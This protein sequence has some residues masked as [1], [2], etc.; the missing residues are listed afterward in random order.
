MTRNRECETAAT[1]AA[2]FLRGTFG[3][4]SIPFHPGAADVLARR[5]A[6]QTRDLKARIAK[7][8]RRLRE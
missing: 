7:G 8:L 5:K 3:T 4:V 6:F 1:L 2:V